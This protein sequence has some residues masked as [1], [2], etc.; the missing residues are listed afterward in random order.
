MKIDIISYGEPLIRLTPERFKTFLKSDSWQVE[1]GGAEANVLAGCSILGLKTQLLGALPDSFLGR[2]VAQ[3][4]RRFGVGVD[5][6][7]LS[8][9]GRMGLY[10]LELAHLREG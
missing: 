9:E 2:R 5:C 1:I 3:E 10:F 7:E 4:L 6:V 8:G